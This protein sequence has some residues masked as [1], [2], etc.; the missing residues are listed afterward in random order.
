[1][2]STVDGRRRFYRLTIE[3]LPEVL[4][5][6]MP[7]HRVWSTSLDRLAGVLVDEEKP[8]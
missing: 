6:V 2:A 1:M 5:W 8:S 4:A 3:P 7:Y